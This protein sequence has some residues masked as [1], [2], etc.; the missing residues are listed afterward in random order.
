MSYVNRVFRISLQNFRKWKTDYRIWMIAIVVLLLIHS[1]IRNMNRAADVLQ[2]PQTLWNYPFLYAQFYQKLL[3]TLPLLF[4]F[5]DAPFLDSNQI[6]ITIR[7]GR[8]QWCL[9]QILYIAMASAIY[10]L[11]L[12]AATILFSLPRAEWSLEWGNVLYTVSRYDIPGV[13]MKLINV[14][15]EVLG[16]FTPL[17]A[18]WFT[19]LVSWISGILLGVLV[20]F[21]NVVSNTRTVGILIGAILIVLSAFLSNEAAWMSSWFS[22]FS[23]NTLNKIDIA[24]QTRYPPFW[25]CMSF[26]AV[27]IAALCAGILLKCRTLLIIP[28]KEDAA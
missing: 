16:Y 5:C 23:W 20:Y 21:C 17:Q 11:F 7:S 27:G 25:Y 28:D 12:I 4:I 9:G 3:F 26:Y 22:P 6:F 1:Y 13:S 18:M 19:F 8:T 14:S 2:L 15:K 24:G 10:Y